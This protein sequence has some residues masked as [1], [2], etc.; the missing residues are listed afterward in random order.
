MKPVLRSLRFRLMVYAV[1][2]VVAALIITGAG[3]A[4]LFERHARR[5]IDAEL[6]VHLA[7]IV[8]ALRFA[9]DGTASL[10]HQPA[11]PRFNKIYGGLFWQVSDVSGQALLRSRSL[12]D[13]ELRL[14]AES[15]V[16]GELYI[17][18]IPGPAETT[19]LV[20]EKLVTFPTPQGAMP[21]RVSVAIDVAAMK[22]LVSGFT[23]DMIP[24]LILLGFALLVGFAV[25]VSAG[26]RPMVALREQIAAIR[27]GRQRRLSG[28]VPQE[29]APLAAEM[30]ELLANQEQD[31][32]RARDRAADMAHGLKTPLTALAT[33]VRRL[34]EKGELEIADDIE[35][36]ANRMRRHLERELARAR[37]R[38]GRAALRTEAAP[39]IHGIVRT[40]RRTPRGQELTFDE[41]VPDDFRLPVDQDDLAEVLGNLIENA[42]R[43]AKST[44]RKSVV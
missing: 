17:R 34:R 22:D 37:L 13:S 29:I 26:L 32:V 24:A 18:E 42:S 20:H 12:W 25:Q 28:P 31:M 16:P 2:V 14:P 30:N 21:L 44:D 3:V 43:H 33:D 39:V 38:H 19:V 1:V 8:G 4:K 27:E 23:R 10:A 41:S 11:D 7:Q 40:L 9:Q 5:Q 6:D 15:L 36:L 35:D